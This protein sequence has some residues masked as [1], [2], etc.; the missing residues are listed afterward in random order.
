[1]VHKVGIVSKMN[2]LESKFFNKNG[3]KR[4]SVLC[5]V[6]VSRRNG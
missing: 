3:E 5:T 4:I 6:G 1:M 2:T